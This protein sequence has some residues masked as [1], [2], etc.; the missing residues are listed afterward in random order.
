MWTSVDSHYIIKIDFMWNLIDF[1]IL[2]IVIIRFSHVLYSVFG[3]FVWAHKT[4][5][6]KIFPGGIRRGER[7]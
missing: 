6:L 4:H 1:Y 5:K 3:L 7:D 2:V